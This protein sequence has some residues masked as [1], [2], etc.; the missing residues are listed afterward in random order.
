VRPS[1]VVPL[2]AGAVF[3]ALATIQAVSDTDLWWH[4]ATGQQ[5]LAHGLARTDAFAWTIVGRP[6]LLDQWLG[7]VLIALAYAA[8]S[9]H[10]VIAL[11][12]LAVALLVTLV[13]G[14]A[15]AER[16]GRPLVALLAALP[17]IMLSRSAYGDRPQLEGY[18]LFAALIWLLRAGQ[19]GSLPA[20]VATAPLLALWSNLHGSSALGLGLILVVL[21]E[22]ALRD[23]AFRRTA[24]VLAVAALLATLLTPAGF[25]SWASSGGHFLAPPRYI[26]E[27]G[28]PNLR[29]VPGLIFAL[30]L[31]LVLGTAFLGR[32]ARRAEAALL[33][34]VVFVSLTAARHMPFFAI[35]AAPYLAAEGPAALAWLARLAGISARVPDASPA[36][37]SWQVDVAAAALAALVLS[38]AAAAAPGDPDESFYPRGALAALPRGPGLLNAYDWGGWLIW[39][40]P[41]TPVFIDGR[42]FPF[43]PDGLADYRSIV[44]LH[45]DW[46]A[47]LDRRGVRALLLRPTDAAAVRA[48]ETGWTVV[49]SGPDFV[50][51]ARP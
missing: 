40:A 12:A 17:A 29:S 11:R 27:E 39:N 1:L 18:V 13:V 24:A 46:R 48:R 7:D 37:S 45:S 19:K 41:D 50:L 5:T 20:L 32:G 3:G 34:P 22:R 16:P 36:R 28:V 30:V 44:G 23:G 14:A 21:A 8:G 25:G 2:A 35:A 26:E 42:L 47:V 31:A 49:A 15:L 6:V 33:L 38:V 4:L 9:W 51:L 43:V 10:G